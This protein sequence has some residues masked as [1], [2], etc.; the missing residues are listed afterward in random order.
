M[1]VLVI[2]GV[3]AMGLFLGG[4]FYAPLIGRVLGE[5]QDRVTAD[6]RRRSVDIKNHVRPHPSQPCPA[7]GQSRVIVLGGT[8]PP[9]AAPCSRFVCKLED[10]DSSGV[11]LFSPPGF[12]R[13]SRHHG[14][15]SLT[16]AA[17]PAI[18]TRHAVLCAAS[19]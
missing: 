3:A 7:T 13:L 4:R 9:P 6:G 11:G 16:R 1:I 19:S 15:S 8:G 18:A 2:I 17:L 14:S 5:R 12:S 10:P